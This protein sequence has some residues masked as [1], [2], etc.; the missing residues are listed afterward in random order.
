MRQ[1]SQSLVSGIVLDLKFQN[2]VFVSM[3]EAR[4]F[5]KKKRIENQKLLDEYRNRPC[6][7]CGLAP[8]SDPHHLIS[9]GAGGDDTP[10]NLISLCRSHHIQAHTLGRDRFLAKYPHIMLKRLHH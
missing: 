1:I 8:K 2:S 9:R 4:L 5:P 7:V 3:S 10:E 6:E